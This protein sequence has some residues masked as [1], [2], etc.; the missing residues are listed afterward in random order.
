[1]NVNEL[2]MFITILCCREVVIRNAPA[3]AAARAL[4]AG[5]HQKKNRSHIFTHVAAELF[6]NPA[7]CSQRLR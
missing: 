7:E 6:W 3:D 4:F 1:M 2:E 5:V